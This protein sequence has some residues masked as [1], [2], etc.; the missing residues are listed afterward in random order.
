MAAILVG[1][2]ATLLGASFWGVDAPVTD[3]RGMPSTAAMGCAALATGVAALTPGAVPPKKGE[4]GYVRHV[5]SALAEQ[6]HTL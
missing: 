2:G 3:G 4:P 1:Y 6:R 5:T